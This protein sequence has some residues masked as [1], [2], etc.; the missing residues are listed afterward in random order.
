MHKFKQIEFNGVTWKGDHVVIEAKYA[1]GSKAVVIDDLSSGERLATVSVNLSEYGYVTQ[2]NAFFVKDYSENTGLG[3]ALAALGV[4]EFTG[5]EV[6]FGY[7][8]T[9]REAVLKEVK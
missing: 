5:R 9:A 4:I 3:D 8:A 7:G 2:D 1:D 6:S